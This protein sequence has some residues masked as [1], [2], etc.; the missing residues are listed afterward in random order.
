MAEDKK[1]KTLEAALA[2]LEAV[3]SELETAKGTITTLV[4]ENRAMKAEGGAPNTDV[5][6]ILDENRVLRAQ[7]LEL[8]GQLTKRI[9]AK[10]ALVVLS[11]I[12]HSGKLYAIGDVYD[13]P[14]VTALLKS[15]SIKLQ[16]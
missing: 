5:A 16:D 12:K 8:N 6:A 14:N 7:L 11:P 10:G 9:A 15:G 4:E 3:S 2:A 13:G 1:P